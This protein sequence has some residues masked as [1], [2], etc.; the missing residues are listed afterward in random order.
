MQL[1]AH[2]STAFHQQICLPLDTFISELLLLLLFH[3]NNGFVKAPQRYVVR[4]L[5]VLLVHQHVY[6]PLIFEKKTIK[7]PASG[8]G[9]HTDKHP[10]VTTVLNTHDI[11]MHIFKWQLHRFY[12]QST[13]LQYRPQYR[14][15]LSSSKRNIVFENHWQLMYNQV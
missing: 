1:K 2:C 7:I 5:S 4:A 3:G 13:M 12:R 9:Q 15:S 11:K 14:Y 10:A 6:R 8:C